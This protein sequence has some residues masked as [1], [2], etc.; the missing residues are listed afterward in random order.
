MTSFARARSY[1][2]DESSRAQSLVNCLVL[3][4]SRGGS[5]RFGLCLGFKL[6]KK[7]FRRQAPFARVQQLAAL[8][9][10]CARGGIGHF[11]REG[12]ATL[13]HHLS[14][15][16]AYRIRDIQAAVGQHG[17]GLSFQLRRD[18]G[19]NL[20]CHVLEVGC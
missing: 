1:R 4:E 15:K 10:R 9:K 11:Y 6:R 12:Q 7:F 2:P 19:A 13:C 17:S 18:A 3:Y 16:K 8:F 5:A 14:Q 20:G